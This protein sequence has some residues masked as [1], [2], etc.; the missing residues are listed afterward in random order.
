MQR[1]PRA[2]VVISSHVVSGF[3]LALT[4]FVAC[5][6]ASVFAQP[7]P[8]VCAS[9]VYSYNASDHRSVEAIIQCYGKDAPRVLA[10][11][12]TESRTRRT[13]S[14]EQ[15]NA[16]NDSDP[17][18][19]YLVNGRLVSDTQLTDLA[20]TAMNR[21]VAL[22]SVPIKK[23]QLFA[24]YSASVKT[25]QDQNAAISAF[26]ASTAAAGGAQ[27]EAN[28]QAEAQSGGLCAYRNN[29]VAAAVG[30]VQLAQ[31]A[32]VY[33]R[34][35][36]GILS[37]LAP[38]VFSKCENVSPPAKPVA[39]LGSPTVEVGKTVKLSVTESGYTGT[40]TV[41]P[42]AEGIVQVA[43]D[44]PT[45][46]HDTDTDQPVTPSNSFTITGI[47]V[48]TVTL[49]VSDNRGQSTIVALTVTTAT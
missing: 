35:Q 46:A 27:N 20:R 47:G 19:A 30:L 28:R 1:H 31:N 37:L 24:A 26:N 14:G 9:A 2:T 10:R 48:G 11:L 42:S 40:F 12:N 5:S 4:L 39:T 29:S 17:V 18:V 43:A 16:V 34:S 6:A 21:G 44:A 25:A 41:T 15:P 22:S 32:A 36:L 33:T 13:T 8:D 3:C 45:K 49:T 38:I 7:G 23:S